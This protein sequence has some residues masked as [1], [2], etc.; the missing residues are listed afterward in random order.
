[1][2]NLISD[3]KMNT[4]IGK[5]KNELYYVH[6]LNLKPAETEINGKKYDLCPFRTQG[7]TNACVGKN[8]HFAM[9]NGSAYKAQV[10]RTTMYFTETEYFYKQLNAEITLIKIKAFSKKSIAVIRLN[11]YSDIN[12]EKQSKRFL[13]MSIYDIHSDVIFYDYTKDKKKTK[14]N[15]AKNYFLTYSHNED[16]SIEETLSFLKIGINPAIVF[17]API[18]K[19]Y[20]GYPVF[21]GDQDDN[22]FLDPKGH[23]IALKFKGS[24]AKLLKGIA[25]GFVISQ[26]ELKSE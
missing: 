10:R 2:K 1:M 12:H 9:K 4:K 20:K 15:K 17:E 24:K 22:R 5:N 25:S 23:I 21:D 6:S 11:A 19:T 16:T 26:A 14:N 7:C 8:G 13:G 3:G 18:P